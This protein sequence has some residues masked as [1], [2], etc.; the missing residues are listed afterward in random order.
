M[1]CLVV[2]NTN[3]N[4]IGKKI[5]CGAI[6]GQKDE[7]GQIYKDTGFRVFEEA[8]KNYYVRM[9]CLLYF[10]FHIFAFVR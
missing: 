8:G 10:I 9:R 2:Y 4:E 7:T 1:L 3:R 6:R 5:L